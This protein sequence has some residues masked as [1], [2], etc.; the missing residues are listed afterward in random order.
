MLKST[1]LIVQRVSQ[2]LLQMPD[3]VRAFQ[4]KSPTAV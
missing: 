2:R 3:L 4:R 1:L